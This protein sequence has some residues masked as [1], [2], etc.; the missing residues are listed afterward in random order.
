[1]TRRKPIGPSVSFFA[2]QDV[3]TSVVG[4]FV[5]ITLIM[6]LELATKSQVHSPTLSRTGEAQLQKNVDLV[7]EEVEFLKEKYAAILSRKSEEANVNSF[8]YE[9]VLNEITQELDHLTKIKSRFDELLSQSNQALLEAQNRRDKLTLEWE[10]RSSDRDELEKLEALTRSVQRQL[11]ELDSD[12]PLI[13]RR[14]NIGDRS[15]VLVDLSSGGIT[16]TESFD[17][18]TVRFDGIKR[19]REFENWLNSPSL[20]TKHLIIFVRPSSIADFEAIEE[21]LR[22]HNAYFGFD[23]LAEHRSIQ[24]RPVEGTSQK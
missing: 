13:F 21:L 14:G 2:F 5:L 20:K 24:F 19:I 18:S 1:M 15:L 7:R 23:L 17:L 3:I 4:I 6:I 9:A 10:A 8:N 12:N 22:I 11:G 16:I